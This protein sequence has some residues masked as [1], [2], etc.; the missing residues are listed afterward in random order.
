M[1]I[2]IGANLPDAAACCYSW[3]QSRPGLPVN[4][5]GRVRLHNRFISADS[6]RPR[7]RV[8]WGNGLITF[9][10]FRSVMKRCMVVAADSRSWNTFFTF[11]SLYLLCLAFITCRV[12]SLHSF[13]TTM[14]SF[15]RVKSMRASLCAQP[16]TKNF[17]IQDYSNMVKEWTIC[18]IFALSLI[19][20]QAG[21]NNTRKSF[22][23]ITW[24][25]NHMFLFVLMV[26]CCSCLS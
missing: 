9:S 13:D 16:Q 4:G 20:L 8:V 15:A 23:A 17:L 2:F 21:I 6:R 19:S 5:D 25:A 10:L 24:N 12:F 11:R 26:A 1:I 22:T 14:F 18:C 7:A 3:G